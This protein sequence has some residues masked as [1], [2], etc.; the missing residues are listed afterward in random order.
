MGGG[1]GGGGLMMVKDATRFHK[2]HLEGRGMLECVCSVSYR[3]LS[4][5]RELQSLVLTWRGCITQNN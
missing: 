2:C 5:G 3:I 1:G 4:L